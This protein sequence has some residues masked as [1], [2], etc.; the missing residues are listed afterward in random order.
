MATNNAGGRVERTAINARMLLPLLAALLLSDAAAAAEP[1]LGYGSEPFHERPVELA[2]AFG[3]ERLAARAA[4]IA[5]LPDAP[6]DLLEEADAMRER[7]MPLFFAA[8]EARDPEGA[9][10]LDA[11]LDRLLGGD[12]A[13]VD[14]AAVDAARDIEARVERVRAALVPEDDAALTAALIVTLLNAEDGVADAYEEAAEGALW[15]YPRGWA[16]LQRA[17]ALWESLPRDRDEQA[18]EEVDAMLISLDA[19]LPQ[20]EPPARILGDPEA[21][22]APIQRLIGFLE[23]VADA[24]LYPARDLARGAAMVEDVAT[25]ACAPEAPAQPQLVAAA[26]F[27]FDGTLRRP[28]SV[29]APEAQSAAEAAFRALGDPADASG[30]GCEDLLAALRAGRAALTP[31]PPPSR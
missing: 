22:E 2:A 26:R 24:D 18:A 9:E 8:L 31:Q 5:A 17:K 25:R 6:A 19:L 1:R 21:P 15:E 29:L 14:G 13:A 11:A 28:L 30:S 7:D 16:A 20:A 4:A 3:L 23:V 27:Y 10:A 12:G